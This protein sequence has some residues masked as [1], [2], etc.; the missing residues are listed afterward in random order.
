MEFIMSNLRISQINGINNNTTFKGTEKEQ[1][2][3]Q[4][5]KTM[6]TKTKVFIGLGALAAATIGTLLVRK[7]LSNKTITRT[8]KEIAEQLKAFKT[9][10]S[11]K[12]GATVE[13]TIT[14]VFGKDSGIT[15]HTYDTS[16][17]FH[18]ITVYRD[19]GGYKD[20]WVNKNGIVSARQEKWS[21]YPDI[22]VASRSIMY[23][24]NLE[25]AGGDKGISVLKGTIEGTKNKVVR[26]TIADP[27]D[28]EN[29][30]EKITLCLISPNNK[31]TS[32]QKDLLKLAQNPKKINTDII[33]NL[34]RFKLDY[35]DGLNYT[36]DE[37]IEKAGQYAN[38]DY[39]LIL[40]AIQSM[41][42]GL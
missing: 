6:E 14:N 26:L 20:G 11:E 32:A 19:Q 41:A 15:P 2:A 7:K 3:E 40:S 24:Q 1:T 31:Y 28:F 30:G 33:D 36:H 34:T 35:R 16:K 17:E 21:E 12:V 23:V 22:K 42:K 29:R 38:L 37:M 4:P 9:E 13:E 39:D 27:S 10:K 5:K 8:E 18:T 25:R